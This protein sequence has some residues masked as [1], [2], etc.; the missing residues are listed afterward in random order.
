M[1]EY[2]LP[3]RKKGFIDLRGIAAGRAPYAGR[4]AE[5]AA[6]RAHVARHTVHLRQK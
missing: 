6:A 4:E 5:R 1:S 3:V 2:Q